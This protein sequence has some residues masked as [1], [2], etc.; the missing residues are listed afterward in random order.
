MMLAFGCNAPNEGSSS[1]KTTIGSVD[2]GRIALAPSP[3]DSLPGPLDS[4]PVARQDSP[5]KTQSGSLGDRMQHG[6]KPPPSGWNLGA[7]Y[8]NTPSLEHNER[9]PICKTSFARIRSDWSFDSNLRLFH[10]REVAVGGL[11]SELPKMHDCLYCLPQSDI[12]SLF[13]K[14]SKVRGNELLYFMNI[15]CLGD[16]GLGKEGCEYLRVD[17]AA[18]KVAKKVS[19]FKNPSTE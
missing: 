6:Q 13:G 8:E 2:S 3:K 10:I 14:P 18:N 5:K 15:S 16:G 17:L 4:I 7:P 9:I 1:E 12:E 11:R 19:I